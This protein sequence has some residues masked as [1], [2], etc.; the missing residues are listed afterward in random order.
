MT[1]KQKGLRFALMTL[2]LGGLLT[3]S[4]CQSAIGLGILAWQLGLFDDDGNGNNPPQILTLTAVP[5]TIPAGGTSVLTVVAVDTDSDDLTYQWTTDHGTLQSPSEAVT[6][7][8]APSGTTGTFYINITVSD[9]K[10]S[11]TASVPVVVTLN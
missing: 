7:W 1:R 6:S 2:I 4:G 5:D 3:L 8:L 9:S 11:I 10:D